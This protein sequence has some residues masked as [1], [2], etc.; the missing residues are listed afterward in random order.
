MVATGVLSMKLS[1]LGFLQLGNLVLYFFSLTINQ[2]FRAIVRWLST[3]FAWLCLILVLLFNLTW[4]LETVM[5]KILIAWMTMANLICL[6]LH[7]CFESMKWLIILSTLQP[8]MQQYH[9]RTGTMGYVLTH[10]SI[11]ASMASAVNA[12]EDI[13]L[14]KRSCATLLS[15][16]TVEKDLVIATQRAEAAA[17]EGPRTLPSAAKCTNQSIIDPPCFR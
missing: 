8:N 10:V 13:K 1:G 4:K 9:A 11:S 17:Q 2:S 12:E 15:K 6:S 3:S 5:N 14:K 16:L 7:K